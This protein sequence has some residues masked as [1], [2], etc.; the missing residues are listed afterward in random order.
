MI[1]KA[2]FMA[3]AL[4]ALQCAWAGK[5][6]QCAVRAGEEGA[7][8]ILIGREV[9]SPLMFVGNNQFDRD[10]VLLDE[11]RLAAE[12][13]VKLFGFQVQLDWRWSREQAEETIAKFC[14]A[15]PEGYF[16][17][18]VWLG[19]T[20]KWL[21]EHPEACIVKADGTRL[22]WVS[23]AS[24][25][26]REEAAALLDARVRQVLDGPYAERFIGVCLNNMQT[27]EWF[28]RFSNEFVDYSPANLAAFRSWLKGEYRTKRALSAA[29]SDA[30]VTFGTAR[31]PSGQERSRGSWGAFRDPAAQQRAIDMQRFQSDQIADTIAYFARV[32]KRATDGRSLVG[33]FYGYTMELN[34][35]GPRV[36]ANSGHLALGRLLDCKDLDIIHAPYSY[37]ERA[38]GEPGHLHLPVDSLALHGKL[39]ILEEDT[40]THLAV[41]SISNDLI[42]PGWRER[43]QDYE[44]TMAVVW[45]NCGNF[46][47]HRSGVWFFDLLSDGRW[48]DREIWKSAVLLRRMIAESRD[49]PVFRPEVALVM[50][51]GAV[52]LMRANTRPFLQQSLSH[53]RAELDRLGTPVGYYLQQDLPRL[54]DSV[55]VLIL[56]NSFLLSGKELEAVENHLGRGGTVIWTYAPGI[57]GPEGPDPARIKDITGIDAAARFD[58]VP[59]LVGSVVTPE[60]V[61]LGKESWEPRFVVTSTDI[62]ILARYKQTG[63]GA[64]ASVPWKGGISVY[65][66]I[67]RLPRGLLRRICDQSGVHLYRDTPGMTGVF[68]SYLVIH[69]DKPGTHTLSWPTTPGTITR[70]VPGQPMPITRGKRTWADEL[71]GH[72]TAIYRM[73]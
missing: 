14:E 60:T 12:A 68:G 6:P 36:L 16:Y 61:D 50:D 67:P 47:T 46:L 10:E 54:P 37:F 57:F 17:I 58:D 65:T 70:L 53:W 30:E 26:W 56:A 7:P 64:A 25:V 24:K 41:K 28:Y 51:E 21:G 62:D 43:T 35:N 48:N 3:A 20:P 34:N 4:L 52:H 40:Y 73:E 22:N 15:H 18:R 69:T 71:P 29:W 63:E 27:G 33:A 8:A 23:P 31:F 42:A 13:G 32:V 19:A 49:E 72:T 44:E 5:P 45:R 38:I 55:K 59:M 2:T 1:R 66:A 11:L 9:H 39:A